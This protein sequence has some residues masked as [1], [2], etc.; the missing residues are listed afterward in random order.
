MNIGVV[1]DWISFDHPGLA[2][3][4]VWGL[5]KPC[6]WAQHQTVTLSL[7]S[8]YQLPKA[9]E[10]LSTNLGQTL[11]INLMKNL[12]IVKGMLTTRVLFGVLHNKK[13]VQSAFELGA[14]R[15]R[16]CSRRASCLWMLTS[17]TMTH[18]SSEV[19][20]SSS[21]LTLDKYKQSLHPIY[22]AC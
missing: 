10:S 12:Q 4:F 20:L 6:M 18:L 22:R 8:P 2:R 5:V 1:I 21:S 13:Y 9:K 11:K 17:R 7:Y 16:D 19:I 14:M 3:A 15:S